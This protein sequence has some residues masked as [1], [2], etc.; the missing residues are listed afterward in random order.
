MTRALLLTLAALA[1]VAGCQKEAAKETPAPAPAAPAGADPWKAKAA[2]KDPLPHPLFWSATKD[3]K[4]LYML[5]T[6][7][8]GV[9][10][11]TRLP[12]VVWQKLDASPAF[13]METDLSDP[14]LSKELM[15]PQT[16]SLH[17]QL[18]DADWQ[19]LGTILGKRQVQQ[20]EHMR[21]MLAA[22]EIEL[23]GMPPTAP[24]DA[25]LLGHAQNKGKR[26]IYLEPAKL[27]EDVLMKW[28]DVRALKLAIEHYEEGKTKL[29][30]L[31]AS[32]VEG[33]ETKMNKLTEDEHADAIKYGYTEEEYAAEQDDLLYKRNA[34]WIPELEQLHDAGGGFVAVGAMH[35]LGPKGVLAL[36]QA[37]GYTVERLH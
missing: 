12:E 9:D 29:A 6:I 4:T 37:D 32:Y 34:S 18:G 24:M 10:A 3:G 21:P 16:G 22:M 2:V 15:A 5:G 13:A 30:D 36:L 7:H 31:L 11:E 20:L 35:Y 14:G 8:M 33:D 27:Q 26:I 19:K 28:L 1:A 25:V 17:E 23:A